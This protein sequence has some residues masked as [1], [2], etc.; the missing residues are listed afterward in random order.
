MADVVCPLC[1]APAVLV[2]ARQA[3]WVQI[4]SREEELRGE[5]TTLCERGHNQPG[6]IPR[7]QR[8]RRGRTRPTKRGF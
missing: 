6:E 1:G 3:R 5:M 2:G 7:D 8:K 4:S